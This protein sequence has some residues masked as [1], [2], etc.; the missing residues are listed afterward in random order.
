MTMYLTPQSSR[1]RSQTVLSNSGEMLNPI[2]VDD[3]PI[4][5]SDTESVQSNHELNNRRKVTFTGELMQTTVTLEY[6]RNLKEQSSLHLSCLVNQSTNL[7]HRFANAENIRRNY[8]KTKVMRHQV[9]ALLPPQLSEKQFGREDT[10]AQA[11]Q[12]IHEAVVQFPLSE[13]Q[14]KLTKA[15]IECVDSL[16]QDAAN[17]QDAQISR[18]DYPANQAILRL[19]VMKP[20]AVSQVLGRLN[21]ALFRIKI[22]EADKA[23]KD[24]VKAAA[25]QRILLPDTE[26]TTVFALM[27]W[28]YNEKLDMDDSDLLC[29]IYM[30]GQHLG[31]DDLASVSLQV[32]SDSARTTVEGLQTAGIALYDILNGHPEPFKV[33]G[34]IEV[35]LNP[36]AVQA[37]FKFVLGEETAPDSLKDFVISAIVHNVADDGDPRVMEM[38]LGTMKQDMRAVMCLKLGEKLAEAW[39]KQQERQDEVMKLESNSDTAETATIEDQVIAKTEE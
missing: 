25:Q 29:K 32:L 10:V 22:I 4:T 26:A 36:E 11:V 13:Y 34:S 16:F 38:V 7:A 8:A 17:L 24:V 12:L 20:L 33:Q 30:L 3:T 6:G 39:A 1:S 14:D 5:V 2:N 18:R 27:Q 35:H 37:V 31:L 23:K 9:K 21:L 15:I 19:Q 28:L